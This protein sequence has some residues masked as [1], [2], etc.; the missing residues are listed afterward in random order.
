MKFVESFK[1]E[2]FVKPSETSLFDRNG[3]PIE[4][5]NEKEVFAKSMYID[6]GDNA[7]QSKYFLRTHNNVPYDP[8]GQYS[9]RETY[10]RTELRP[11]SKQT[12]ESY[13]SYLQTK[14]QLHM[15]KAQRGFIN[16]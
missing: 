1:K 10:L 4:T 16:G 8:N 2:D 13:I 3:K 15:T 12:F 14:N 11:V 5:N 7:K 6:I 9:H